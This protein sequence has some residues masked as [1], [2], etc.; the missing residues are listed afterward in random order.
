MV[1]TPSQTRNVYGVDES[2]RCDHEQGNSNTSYINVDDDHAPRLAEQ[3]TDDA[4]NSLDSL[5]V[6]LDCPEKALGHSENSL[7]SLE[8]SL[9]RPESSLESLETSLGDPER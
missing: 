8:T 4:E 9:V 7:V 6:S 3:A 5:E 1:C 2:L